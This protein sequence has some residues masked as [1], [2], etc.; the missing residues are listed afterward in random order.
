MGQR[1]KGQEVQV[2][3]IA[4]GVPVETLTAVKSFEVAFQIDTLTEGYLGETTDRRDAIFKGI[5]GKMELHMEDQTIL[6]LARAI[7][8]KAR[9]RT[10]NG[11]MTPR[12][13]AA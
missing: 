10:P 3:L 8:D 11:R 2:L 1:I 9:R 4:G 7:I 12:R 13:M 6:I 5:S